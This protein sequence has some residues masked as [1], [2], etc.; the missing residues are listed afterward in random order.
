[1][2]QDTPGA[3]P[4]A[5]P[6]TLR[7]IDP[8]SIPRV[9]VSGQL[10]S[11]ASRWAE[12]HF[13]L[14]IALVVLSRLVIFPARALILAYTQSYSDTRYFLEMVRLSD[15]GL[16]PYI[17]F[18]VEYPPIYPWL[19]V[20]AYKLSTTLAAGAPAEAL[21]YLLLGA[22]HVAFELVTLAMIYRLAAL[23]SN[24]ATA[25][26]SVLIYAIL[27][28]PAYLWTGWFDYLPEFLF[29]AGLYWLLTGR[30]GR[31]A[32]AAGF[33]LMAKL[34]PVV[35]VPLALITIQ[36]LRRKAIYLVTTA[37]AVALFAVP[38]ALI[39][40]NML[41]ASL[42][43]TFSRPSW[44]TIWALFDRYYGPGGVA[45]LAQHVSPASAF[46]P[47]HQ[48]ATPW[49]PVTLVFALAFGIFYWRFWDSQRRLPA[50]GRRYRIVAAAGFSLQLL[51]LYSRG[52]SPQYLTWIA[53]LLVILM[54]T[55]RGAAYLALLSLVNL[56]ELPVFFSFFP[57]RPAILAVC[58]VVRA[59]LF[60]IIAWN[61]LSAALNLGPA[62]IRPSRGQAPA[63]TG[64][65]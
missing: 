60:V 19:S 41:A 50:A 55:R 10:F 12:A 8:A 20:L 9:N 14:V 49:L 3:L 29:L 28:V 38:L 35:L 47:N 54:P 58:I 45:P 11:R 1:M 51:L 59:V 25:R 65:G 15:R 40:R 26:R 42:L 7:R 31:S 30:E 62:G 24:P 56:I 21:F 27:F 39:N 4:A 36:G 46:V 53:P 64:G 32:L 22:A 13:T 2:R 6:S 44:E 33:G 17:H 16:Y 5:Y 52:Y 43:N 61:Y 48:S 18:W 63:A 23:L 34:F 37:A 57:D